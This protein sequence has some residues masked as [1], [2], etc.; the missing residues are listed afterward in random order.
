METHEQLTTRR[1]TQA[2][3]KEQAHK[4]H[5]LRKYGTLDQSK[6][7]IMKAALAKGDKKTFDTYRKLV[8]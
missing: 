8:G 3:K 7:S 6:I 5:L 4:E 2:A 1:L